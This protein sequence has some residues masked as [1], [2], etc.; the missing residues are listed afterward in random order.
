MQR[1]S[2]IEL[3]IRGCIAAG[4]YNRAADIAFE[5]GRDAV[6]VAMQSTFKDGFEEAMEHIAHYATGELKRKG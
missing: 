4:D 1:T 2:D 6:L 3:Q 5:N